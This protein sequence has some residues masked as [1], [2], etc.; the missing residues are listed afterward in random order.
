M[1][2][3]RIAIKRKISQANGNLETCLNYLGEILGMG[4]SEKDDLKEQVEMLS[5][6]IIEFQTALNRLNDRI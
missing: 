5:Q 1:S 2:K 4:I 3:L 6:A